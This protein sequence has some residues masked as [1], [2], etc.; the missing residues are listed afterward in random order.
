[1]KNLLRYLISLGLLASIILVKADLR[2]HQS[3]PW[4]TNQLLEP[5]VLASTI[6][7]KKATQPYTFCIGPGAIIPHSIDMGPAK[8]KENLN[9]F[10]K[11]FN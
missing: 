2:T 10:P 9:P 1:M 3:E 4:A 11:D 7:S 8:E 6:N 5:S